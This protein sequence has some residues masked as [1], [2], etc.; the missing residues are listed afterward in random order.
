MMMKSVLPQQY[1][2]VGEYTSFADVLKESSKDFDAL[3]EMEDDLKGAMDLQPLLHASVLF[4]KD[5]SPYPD[6]KACPWTYFEAGADF[7]FI[8]FESQLQQN[9]RRKECK[10]NILLVW[11]IFL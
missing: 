4:L 6:A 11:I 2:A 7:V 9:F 1:A 3:D 10:S 8:S 5:L